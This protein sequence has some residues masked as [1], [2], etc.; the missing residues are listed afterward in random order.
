M[1]IGVREL[2]L[3]VRY[4]LSRVCSLFVVVYDCYVLFVVCCFLLVVRSA[5]FVARYVLLGVC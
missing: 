1:I 3:V 4:L 5:S 2:L